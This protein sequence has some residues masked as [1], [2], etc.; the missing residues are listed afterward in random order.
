MRIAQV[1][2]YSLSLPGGVQG[3]VLGLARSL[4]A[5]GHA[6][7][8][9]APTDGPPPAPGTRSLGRSIPLASNGSVAPIAPDLACALRTVAA[10]RDGGYDVVHIHEPLVPGPAM[11][12]LLYSER[13]ILATFHRSG[14]S[15]AYVAFKPLVSRWAR[16]ISVRAAVSPE[17]VATARAALGGDYELLFN[18]IDLEP[19]VKAG[20]WPTTRRTILFIGRHEER[21]G[22]AVLLAALERID[23]EVDCWVVGDGPETGRLRSRHSSDARIQWLGRVDDDER[24][25]RMKGAD[26]V[27][28]PSIGGESFGVVVLEAMAAGTPVVAS[29][30]P[31]YRN[32]ARDGVDAVLV[33]PGDPAALAAAL[34]RVLGDG[35]LAGALSGAGEARAAELSMGHLAERYAGL[36]RAAVG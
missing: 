1:C 13:P 8:V 7:T 22:L 20:P 29:D 6:V 5:A 28:A 27:C 3:Q 9:L 10:L 14:G 36:Y 12:A 33:P 31:G 24:A 19:F 21:K 26:V 11:T 2:P 32:V 30:L 35:R 15:K 18:G 4:R 17:A 16:R 23:L 25:S 34:T